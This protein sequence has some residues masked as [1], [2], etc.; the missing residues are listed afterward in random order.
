MALIKFISLAAFP[1]LQVAA[2]GAPTNTTTRA[3]LGQSVCLAQLNTARTDA[4]L[5]AF[6][7]M[8]SEKSLAA[9][10]DNDNLSDN[11]LLKPVCSALLHGDVQPQ[12]AA[13]AMLPK[14]DGTA[15][16]LPLQ[17]SNPE[18]SA[19]VQTFKAGYLN[20]GAI[21]PKFTEE[22]RNVYT[23]PANLSFIALYNPGSDPKADC[24][25]VTCTQ[26]TTVQTPQQQMTGQQDQGTEAGTK[27]TAHALLCLTTPKALQEGKAPFT[28]E[29]WVQLSAAFR[30]SAATPI[31]TF[32]AFAATGLGFA[33]L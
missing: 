9:F 23:D 17:S 26:E 7:S 18:C 33:L 16:F 31:P 4:G 8:P 1:L 22:T 6:S 13:S 27:K 32:L 29:Q 20:F 24:R 10:S 14:L 11:S 21:P 12:V 30:A 5:T 25:V 28:E 19:S 15:A 2:G 3:S